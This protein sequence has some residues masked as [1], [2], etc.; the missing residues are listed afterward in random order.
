VPPVKGPNP[1]TPS[2]LVASAALIGGAWATL[3]PDVTA[4]PRTI[5]WARTINLG[6][7]PTNDAAA[8]ASNIA[9]GDVLSRDVDLN[10]TQGSLANREITLKFAASPT[11]LLDSDPTNG[12]QISIQQ[13][14]QAWQRSVANSPAPAFLYTCAPGAT[15]VKINGADSASVRALESQPGTLT[16]QDPS[17]TGG[18]DFLVLELSLPAA[19]PGDL[20]RVAAC[21]GRPGGT[22]ATED[23]QGCS[24]MLTYT[25]GATQ[26]T[27]AGR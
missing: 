26:P 21:S 7:G 25:F 19:A 12:L 16:P 4:S 27:Q 18:K 24:S 13:C 3:T 1:R 23:L 8:G 14:S 15:T 6:T 10:D 11:S 22:T 2:L 17:N 9:P 20:A 5:T